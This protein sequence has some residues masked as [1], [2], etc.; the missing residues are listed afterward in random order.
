[1]IL[2]HSTAMT[3]R[4]G[5]CQTFGGPIPVCSARGNTRDTSSRRSKSGIVS[6]AESPPPFSTM[7]V[8]AGASMYSK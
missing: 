4:S 3:A 2:V 6:T 1:M 8:L 7:K 5:G